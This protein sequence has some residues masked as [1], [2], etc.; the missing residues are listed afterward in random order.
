MY[1]KRKLILLENFLVVKIC[2]SIN[3]QCVEKYFGKLLIL[4]IK[5]VFQND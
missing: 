4:N 2:Q 3:I 1:E 5:I